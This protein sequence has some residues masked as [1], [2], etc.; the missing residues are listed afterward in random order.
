MAEQTLDLVLEH[1]RFGT[2]DDFEVRVGRHVVDPL[3]ELHFSGR[4]EHPALH[5]ALLEEVF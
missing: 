4:L 3:H 2:S 5:A 1:A